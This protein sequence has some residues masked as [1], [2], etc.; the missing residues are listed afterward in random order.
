ML[1]EVSQNQ[2]GGLIFKQKNYKDLT[3]KIL[4]LLKNKKLYAQKEKECEAIA[5]KYDWDK[6]SKQVF[7]VYNK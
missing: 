5:K 7:E 2:K 6:I 1:K 4:F 3:N